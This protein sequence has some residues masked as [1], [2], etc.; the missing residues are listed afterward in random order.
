MYTERRDYP[1]ALTHYKKTLEG[2]HFPEAKRVLETVSFIEE[3][4][5]KGK[6]GID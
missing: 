2:S 4:L 3:T 5:K 6:G 1:K